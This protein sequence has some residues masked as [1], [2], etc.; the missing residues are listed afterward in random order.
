[1]DNTRTETWKPVVGFPGYQVSDLVN[2]KTWR[3]V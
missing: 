3:H 2:G 1:M